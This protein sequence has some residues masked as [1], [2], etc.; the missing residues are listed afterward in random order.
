MHKEPAVLA[1]ISA[2]VGSIG[3]NQLGCWYS[4]RASKSALNML[5]RTLALEWQRRHP[6]AI[7]V[8]PHPGTTATDLSAPFRQCSA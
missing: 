1:N 5:T 6:N 7:V 2:R 4:Y 8:A 3:D